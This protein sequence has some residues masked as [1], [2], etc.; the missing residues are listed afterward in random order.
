ML[1]KAY[2]GADAP[3]RTAQATKPPKPIRWIGSTREELREFPEPVKRRV[4]GALWEA[5]T[6]SK[7]PYAKPLKGFGG[8]GVLEIVDDFDGNS[9][10]AVYTV[11]FAEAVYVLNVFQKKSK[12]GIATPRTEVAAIEQRLKRARQDYEQW[13]GRERLK[14]R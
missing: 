10:R 13:L 12:R 1:E 8:A 7:A 3:M 6:G 14:S 4:G 2:P 5:Q 9:Y 11:K